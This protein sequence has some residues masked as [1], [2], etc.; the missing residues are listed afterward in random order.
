MKQKIKKI[1]VS[2]KRE[3][4]ILTDM[5]KYLWGLV[6]TFNDFANYYFKKVERLEKQIKKLKERK[7]K[8]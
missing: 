1:K 4:E 6:A 8:T 3:N 2:L 7:L 5:G